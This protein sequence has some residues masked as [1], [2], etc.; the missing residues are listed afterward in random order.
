M[1]DGHLAERFFSRSG[2]CLWEV[3]KLVRMRPPRFVALILRSR[4]VL[5]KAWSPLGIAVADIKC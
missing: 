2:G 5:A 3:R 4:V 1:R